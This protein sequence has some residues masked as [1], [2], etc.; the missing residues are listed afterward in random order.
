MKRVNKPISLRVLT[1]LSLG[2]L[3]LLFNAPI[4]AAGGGH[5]HGHGH[6]HEHEEEHAEPEKG[7][8]GGR[9]LEQDDFSLELKIF[10]TG[11]EP[12]YRVY[13]FWKHK[14]LSPEDVSVKVRLARFAGEEQNFNFQTAGEYLTDSQIVYEPHSF[15]VSVQATYKGQDYKW[16]FESYEGRTSL[17]KEAIKHSDLEFDSVQGRTISNSVK[18]YGRIL[19]NE[20]RV[21]HLSPRFAGILKSISK[22]L[23]DRVKAGET[24]AVIE[25]NQGLQDY[26]VKSQI[27]GELIKRHASLGEFVDAGKE[28]F[29]VADL[30]QVWADFQIFKDVLGEIEVGQTVDIDLGIN[31]A[32]VQGRIS[33]ISPTID[34][35]SQSKLIRVVLPNK[36]GQI[37]PGLFIS[38]NITVSQRQA[39]LAVKRSAL[40]TFRDWQVVF[41]NVGQDFQAIPVEVGQGDSTYVEILSGL[42]PGQRYVSKNSF[43]IKADIEKSGAS[44]DH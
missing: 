42:K 15:D 25:S 27:S 11:Q 22:S 21:T 44:H 37:K 9:L 36:N 29:V 12:V 6:E 17:T 41:L 20:D 4:V 38:G 23:G 24:L 13:P 8:H 43:M 30:E 7:P 14:P 10:E 5:D 33:Y 16:E 26:A 32:I 1:V 40:Q 39:A 34:D 2:I 19:L 28:L 3:T 18:V 31:Q 35:A